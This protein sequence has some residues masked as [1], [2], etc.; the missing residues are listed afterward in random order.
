MDGIGISEDEFGELLRS[1]RRSAFRLETR[2]V[3]ALDFEAP[4]FERF[5][6]GNPVPPPQ[7]GWWKPWLDQIAH[8]TRE[9]KRIGR[10][11][12]LAE[13]PTAY[14]RWE[15]WAAP[16][17]AEAGETIAYMPRSRAH[18]IGL[19]DGTDWW[20]I[21]GEKLIVMEFDATGRV[22]G[23]TLITDPMVLAQHRRWQ[24]LAVRNAVPAED[25]AA[26]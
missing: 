22:V 8:L 24:D 9:G 18:A 10:V 19:P 5:L 2:D 12:I 16:W 20:L 21:D 7:V 26:A 6:A 11:R 25:I 1:P 3:Y 23:K 15:L 14:Q 13:S 4:D 17:H